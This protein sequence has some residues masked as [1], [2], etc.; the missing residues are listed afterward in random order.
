MAGGSW[1][2]E[3]KSTAGGGATP[4]E[5]LLRPVGGLCSDDEKL[6]ARPLYHCPAAIIRATAWRPFRKKTLQGFLDFPL[7]RDSQRRELARAFE[8]R[9]VIDCETDAAFR[10][11]KIDEWELAQR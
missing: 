8:Q 4:E 11:R 3:L 2:R 9:F 5:A 7:V 1:C 10:Q 6:C